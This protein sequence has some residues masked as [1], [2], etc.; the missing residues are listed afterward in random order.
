MERKWQTEKLFRSYNF[1][2]WWL[3]A[4][5]KD[6]QKF[7]KLCLNHG[8]HQNLSESFFKVNFSRTHLGFSESNSVTLPRLLAQMNVWKDED[9]EYEVWIGTSTCSDNKHLSHR[10][11]GHSSLFIF[12]I[13]FLKFYHC[14]FW[15]ILC[16]FFW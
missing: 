10:F 15:K 3:I 16:I 4:L 12:L 1:R 13:V 5:D 7:R 11:I 2:I 8:T 9:I 14:F 6:L